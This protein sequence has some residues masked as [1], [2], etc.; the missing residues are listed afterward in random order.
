MAQAGWGALWALGPPCRV[1][2]RLRPSIG[3]AALWARSPRALHN[4]QYR[5]AGPGPRER[6]PDS[7]QAPRRLRLIALSTEAAAAR[8]LGLWTGLVDAQR[9]AIEVLAV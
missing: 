2:P 1:P 3:Q 5:S 9:P 7:Y 8:P 6:A 4:R